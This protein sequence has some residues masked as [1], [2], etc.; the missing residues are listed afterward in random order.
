MRMSI[1]VCM[2]VIK[3]LCDPRNNDI[4]LSMIPLYATGFIS[5]ITNMTVYFRY[6]IYF[7][8]LILFEKH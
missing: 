7:L 2:F 6:D 3:D 8:T 5:G 1:I 4:F